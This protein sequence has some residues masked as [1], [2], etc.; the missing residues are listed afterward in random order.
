MSEPIAI[1]GIACVYPDANSP[2][3]LWRNVLAGRR[4]FRRLP[5]E[6]L[7]GEDYLSRDRTA[8]DR[9]YSIQAA[10]IEGYEFDRVGFRVSGDS[11]RSADLAHWLALDVASRAMADAGF[12]AGEGLP[13]DT[14]G[15][16]LGNTLTGEFSRAQ[17]IRLRWPFTRRMLEAA[18]RDEGWPSEQRSDFLSRMESRFKEPFAPV[19]EET[20]AGGLSNTIAGRICNHFNLKGGGYTVDGACA[21]SLLAVAHAC[22][23][24]VSSDLDVALAGGV[25]LSLDPFE[26][27]GFAK[28][29]ALAQDDMRIYDAR[30]NGFWPGEGCGVVVLMRLADAL[31]QGRRVVA[32]IRGW[33]VSSDGQGGITRP[34]VEGQ[35]LALRR[36]YRRAGFSIRTVGYFE[37]HGTGTSVGDATEL[38]A[39][40]RAL[41]EAPPDKRE[42]QRDTRFEKHDHEL[43]S[44]F[45]QN[46]RPVIGSIK[47]NVGH[48]KAAAGVAGLIKAALALDAQILPPTTGCE[49]PHP[50]L[51]G[52]NP[53][54]NVLKKGQNWPR[55][56]PLRA[57]VSAMGFGGINA[58]LVLESFARDRRESISTTEVALLESTQ[59]SELFLLGADD[60]VGLRRQI[61]ELSTFAG[62][63][64]ISEL[65]DLAMHLAATL[66]HRTVRAAIVARR[67]AELESRLAILKTRLD[68]V[69]D[70]PAARGRGGQ[71]DLEAGV[72]LGLGILRPRIGF[73]FPGQGAPAARNGGALGRRFAS[74][75]NHF[76][77]AGLPE[78]GDLRSTAIAQPAVVAASLA[79]LELLERLGIKGDVAVGHSLGELTA[80]HWAGAFD[81]ATLLRIAAFR[82][83]IMERYG[84]RG[85]AMASLQAVHAEVASLL[86]GEGVVI[87]GL[88]GP[89]Q[90]VIAGTSESVDLVLSRAQRRGIG[91]TRLAVS[92]AFHSAMM[93][94]A[95]EPLAR[96]LSRESIGQPYRP[97]FSTVTGSRVTADVDLREL[98]LEQ[99]TSPVR[100][101]EA[102]TSAEEQGIDLW[103]EVGPG[104]VL[105]GL[106]EQSSKEPVISIEIGSE[107]LG[108]LLCAAGAAYALGA[109]LDPAMLIDRRASRPFQTPWQPR[110]FASPCEQAPLPEPFDESLL[111]AA[112]AQV[113]PASPIEVP[114]TD[115]SLSVLEM[116]R[117]RVAA[118]VEL[119]VSS[120]EAGSRLLSDLHLNSIAVGQLVSEL[121]R[122]MDLAS[123]IDLLTFADST[124]LEVAEALQELARTGGKGERQRDESL[125]HGVAPWFRAFAPV[126]VDRPRPRRRLGDLQGDWRILSLPENP[127][128][129]RL[130]ET[131]SG[132]S[133]GSGVLV[134]LPRDPDEGHI[135]LL[136]QAA[137]TALHDPRVDRFV[138]VQHGGGAASFARTLAL[139]APRL[140]V[141]VVDVPIGHPQSVAWI[142]AEIE[143]GSGF[144][145][146]HYNAVG[147]RSIPMLCPQ[148]FFDDPSVGSLGPGDVLLV[149]GGGKGIAAEC[150]LSLARESGVA[151]ALMGRSHPE[152]DKALSANLDRMSAYGVR[153]HY[154]AA[155]VIDA[156]AVRAA[157]IEAEARLGPITA[158]LHGAGLNVPRPISSL[159]EPSFRETL[160]P[161][162]QGF[163]NLLASLT[164][165]RLKLLVSFGSIIARTGLPG[166]ADYGL[167]NEW[168]S[169]LTERF[170]LAHPSCRCLALEWSVWS[171]VGMGDRLGRVEALSRRGITP[172]TPDAGVSLFRKLVASHQQSVPIVVAGRFGIPPALAIV[173]DDLPLLRFLERPLVDYPEVELIAEATVGSETDPYL[174]DHVFRGERLFPAVLGLEAMAQTAM[175]VLRSSEVPR[176]E[177]VRFD[178]PIVV[179]LGQP[180]TIRLAAIVI[181]PGRVEVVIRSSATAFQ[182]DH[183][184][185]ICQ[186]GNKESAPSENPEP[187]RKPATDSSAIAMDPPV[188]LYGGL[189]FQGGRFRRLKGYRSLCA[190]GCEA[191]IGKAEPVEWF[192]RYLSPSLVLGDPAARDAAIHAIQ[193]CIPQATI[194]PIGIDRLTI[195]ET[196]TEPHIVVAQQRTE[197]ADLLVYDLKILNEAGRILERWEGLRLRI[198]ERHEPADHWPESLFGPYLE[199]RVQS[200]LPGCSI[201]V[202]VERDS[203]AGRRE[204]SNRLFRRA[205]GEGVS[206]ARRPDGKPEPADHRAISASHSGD[207][208]IAV[209][210]NGTVGCDIER[211]STRPESIWL[212]LL[213]RDRWES[214]RFLADETGESLHMV[215]TR[216]WVGI[217]CL[218]KAGATRLAPLVFDR[219]AQGT[220]VLL[221]S[222]SFRIATFLVP[223]RRNRETLVVGLLVR[224]VHESL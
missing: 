179:S 187:H 32:G 193:A 26:L 112:E 204:R 36:A 44:G 222:G 161:K 214:A 52:E 21:S 160:A 14:T 157:V 206:F 145:E 109:P 73:L 149:S 119:P 212:E 88:N 31:N 152:M 86:N 99:V 5:A 95:V 120:V 24:L 78:S 110:F 72:F 127:L 114:R 135:G 47:A 144:I 15:V 90:T 207:W 4:S 125:L 98:M 53:V 162:L 62:R 198:V 126:L 139:E 181:A 170:Q 18:L 2:A 128:A 29:G 197:Q 165:N 77:R 108:G 56:R 63:L 211:L 182:V 115:P 107:S 13:R 82:G 194:L 92:H 159:D 217:E 136:L 200:L 213:G 118:K 130:R 123:P 96:A 60:P 111:V 205:L 17:A 79:G 89:R 41:R 6:R 141:C 1:V 185:A 65:S 76:K 61:D 3:E 209:M 7:S 80:L 216:I 169:T 195:G 215:A 203:Q 85:G 30:S 43:Y 83:E 186:F 67:P 224:S 133:L 50:E 158:L 28:A 220:A 201:A 25:D 196:G 174:E 202:E 143:A 57:G 71:V 173:G 42:S 176:F 16:F 48:T 102:I 184:R 94:P 23:S 49:Q 91:T 199:R 54:V 20:L 35:L 153:F 75:E 38:R 93:A 138:M 74:V 180:I 178:R 218:A 146:V 34:E 163:R 132:S 172:V 208:T 223:D 101:I 64:S 167:A 27:V 168:L 37:G 46:F 103:I 134:C 19:G 55:D 192:H 100:F 8:A 147:C 219:Q 105:R 58:H 70:D 68:Q 97:L 140:T 59:D 84:D 121:A 166:E 122:Q 10:V 191:L 124:V 106:V 177:E 51:T 155:D 129:E 22:S 190:T 116:V 148:S 164:T 188:D 104:R 142:I 33:G 151:L 137:H 150:A 69:V 45:D 117:H 175:G 189:L 87:A 40:G 210:G 113:K 221:N 154:I 171:G 156:D 131:I 9:T 81:E 11:Y 183:F 39:L 12:E 66:E